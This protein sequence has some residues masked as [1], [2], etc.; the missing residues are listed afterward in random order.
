MKKLSAE[1]ALNILCSVALELIYSKHKDNKEEREKALE[2][3]KLC[4]YTIIKNLSSLNK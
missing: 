3:L 4:E 1:I 2:D